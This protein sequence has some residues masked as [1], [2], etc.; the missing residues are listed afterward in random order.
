V[1]HWQKDHVMQS[2][3]APSTRTRKQ[4]G[5]VMP[6]VAIVKRCFGIH[7]QIITVLLFLFL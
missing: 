4:H 3:A 1:L 7:L 5:D 6:P 2:A